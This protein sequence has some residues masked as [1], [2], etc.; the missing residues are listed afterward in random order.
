MKK[1]ISLILALMMIIY[2]LSLAAFAQDEIDLE[3]AADTALSL[4][5]KNV[6]ITEQTTGAE[7]KKKNADSERYQNYDPAPHS[8]EYRCGN[9]QARG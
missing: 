1:I 7:K 3:A 6:I 2:S 8:G 5:A 4:S 9:N